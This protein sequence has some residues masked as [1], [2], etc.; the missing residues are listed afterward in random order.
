[1][2]TDNAIAGLFPDL[3]QDLLIH[4][5]GRK[6][7]N[8]QQIKRF[9][10]TDQSANSGHKTGVSYSNGPSSGCIINILIRIQPK[11]LILFGDEISQCFIQ[12]LILYIYS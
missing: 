12:Y 7:N 3:I 5:N 8:F 2:I 6:D 9:K 1:M 11:S 10:E 4:K